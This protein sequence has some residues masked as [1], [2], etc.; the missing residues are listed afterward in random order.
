MD[1]LTGY[2]VKSLLC[3]PIKNGNKEVLAVVQA[4]NKSS[5]FHAHHDSPRGDCFDDNDIRVIFFKY[6]NWRILVYKSL[7][8]KKITF[9]SFLAFE[10]LFT[11]LCHFNIQF[12][13]LRFLYI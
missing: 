3:M 1:K 9:T 13:T 8:L 5:I 2:N 4:I 10:R 12:S 11:I 6:C 7:R